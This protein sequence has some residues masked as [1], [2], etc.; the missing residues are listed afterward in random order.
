MDLHTDIKSG[1]LTLSEVTI[2]EA[3]ELTHLLK[4]RWGVH[5][6]TEEE[7]DLIADF[8]VPLLKRFAADLTPPAEHLATVR[9]NLA[10]AMAR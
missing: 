8:I 5:A 4:E 6:A 3:A 9:R 1:T 7:G 10:R 2:D